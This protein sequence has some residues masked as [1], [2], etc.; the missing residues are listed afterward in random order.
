MLHYFNYQLFFDH[1]PYLFFAPSQLHRWEASDLA[2]HLQEWLKTRKMQARV[3]L[4]LLQ[5]RFSIEGCDSQDCV[6]C[7]QNYGFD[8]KV[9][10]DAIKAID[11]DVFE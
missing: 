8:D 11:L 4:P 1:W 9:L 7:R 5:I 2:L 3:T 6:L 10:N